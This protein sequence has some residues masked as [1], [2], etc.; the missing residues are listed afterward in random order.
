MSELQL[1]V[2]QHW[3]SAGEHTLQKQQFMAM[4]MPIFEQKLKPTHLFRDLTTQGEQEQALSTL[5]RFIFGTSMID[6]KL[7]SESLVGLRPTENSLFCKSFG[8]DMQG[9]YIFNRT[10]LDETIK[11]AHEAKVSPVIYM[12][13]L[14]M[15]LGD[16]AEISGIEEGAHMVFFKNKPGYREFHPLKQLHTFSNLVE[17]D[18]QDHEFHALGLK[19]A[20]IQRYFPQYT[21]VYKAHYNEVILQRRGALKVKLKR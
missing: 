3:Q 6:P 4:C 1:D 18:A 10:W 13:G 7:G 12:M 14:P 16:Y 11:K 8:F 19:L 17:Y 21:D 20:Y 5:G 15:P 2:P 9:N